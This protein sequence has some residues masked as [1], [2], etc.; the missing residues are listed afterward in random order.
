MSH[1]YANPL[2][3]LL[4][5]DAEALELDQAFYEAIR[6]LGSFRR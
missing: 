6:N 1:F 3:I 2:S 4:A 5:E